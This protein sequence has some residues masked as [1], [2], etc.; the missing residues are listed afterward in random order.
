[1]NNPY[2]TSVMTDS[3]L[4]GFPKVYAYNGDGTVDTITCTAMIN[5]VE[6]VFVKTYAYPTATS[7]TVSEWEKQA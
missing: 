3:S 1:M 6:T 2:D 5:G 4:E 7:M